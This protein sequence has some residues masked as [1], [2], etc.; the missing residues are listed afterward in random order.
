MLQGASQIW[1]RPEFFPIRCQHINMGQL[2]GV[3]QRI[4]TFP[5]VYLG[6][7]LHYKKLPKSALQ[8]LIQK[9]GNRLPGWKRNLL[10]YPGRELLVKSVLS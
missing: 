10:Y 8:H 6:L 7:P 2:L 9:I 5:C 4:F 1:T 3:D